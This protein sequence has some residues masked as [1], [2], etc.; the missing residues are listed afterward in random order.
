MSKDL[1]YKISA[2]LLFCVPY[3]YESVEL[4]IGLG[5]L[6]TGILLMDTQFKYSRGIVN[7]LLFLVL[8]LG[9]GFIGT[10]LQ[11]YKAYDIVKDISFFI[12][13]IMFIGLGYYLFGKIQDKHFFFKFIIYLALCFS[14]YH[15]IKLA[16]YLPVIRFNFTRIR[17]IFGKSNY[18]EMIALVLLLANSQLKRIDVRVKYQKLILILL[19]VSFVF[20]FS[21]TMV[22]GFLILFLGTLGYL[23][24]TRKGFVILSSFAIGVVLFFAYL[25]TLDLDREADGFEGF[26]YKIKIAPSEIFTTKIDVNN[27]A[28]LWDHWRG[29]EAG[30]ALSQLDKTPGGL[31]YLIGRGLGAQ[32]DLGFK[33]PLQE[34]GIRFIPVTHNGFA[35]VI[36]KTG[37][38]GLLIYLVLL[39]YIY[40]FAYKKTNN[41]SLFFDRLVSSLAVYFFFTSFIITGLYNQDDILTICL[42]V[43]LY[44]RH[45]YLHNE[46]DSFQTETAG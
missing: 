21:R 14:L 1:V 36:F 23:K 8:M 19:A 35:Y 7:V 10:F 40:L 38:V 42:G 44:Y 39:V 16:I 9:V 4:N 32:V 31:G 25:Y 15:L 34:G 17:T 33:A 26:L 28:D 30:K 12:R 5:V 37:V 27:H 2:L 3:F 11:S 20:Y 46:L 13:P 18:I 41:K 29:Y 6:L 45:Y 22:L 24:L 43:F